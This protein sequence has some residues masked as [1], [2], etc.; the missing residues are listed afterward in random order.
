M[1]HQVA[2]RSDR[3]GHDPQNAAQI[4]R[5][6]DIAAGKL[7]PTEADLNFYGHE[8]R[9]SVR[10][11][12]LGYKTGKPTDPDAAD[13]LWN[14]AHTATLEDYGLKEGEGVL[15][16]PSVKTDREIS[17]PLGARG[18][19]KSKALGET[20]TAGGG[21]SATEASAVEAVKL[22]FKIAGKKVT[23][24][25]HITTDAAADAKNFAYTL[26]NAAGEVIYTGSATK[27]LH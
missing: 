5:L 17:K 1:H 19:G 20:A 12:K 7:E 26:R 22:P 15:Y 14:N 25:S 16:H 23:R 2:E 10:Y 6:R 13:R 11:G 3:F 9:E 18:P 21:I 24:A 4:Q 27:Y 8:L